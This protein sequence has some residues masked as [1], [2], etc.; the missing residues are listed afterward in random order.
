[1]KHLD[2]IDEYAKRTWEAQRFYI[3]ADID[4]GE[5]MIAK[6]A[7]TLGISVELYEAQTKQ[8][9]KE[10]IAWD[11]LPENAQKLWS[12][13]VTSDEVI[14]QQLVA[15]RRICEAAKIFKALMN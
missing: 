9:E 3:T 2:V 10:F 5:E 15:T 1:M 11:D 13:Y 6:A 7:A 4:Y 12:A 8:R 14:D